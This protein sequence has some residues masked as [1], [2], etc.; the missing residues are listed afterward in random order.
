[1]TPVDY[2]YLDYYQGDATNEPESI[3]GKTTLKTVY[4]FN[5]TPPVLSPEQQKHILGVQGCVWT[6]YTKTPEL[7]ELKTYPRAIAL[8][9]VAWS[10]QE[11]RNWD[12]FIDRMDNQFPRLQAMGVKY[13][14]GSFVTEISTIRDAANN[15]NLV[16]ISS[17]TKGMD[18]RF[19]TDGSEPAAGSEFFEKPFQITATTIVKSALFR[20]GKAAGSTTQREILVNKASGKPVTILKPYSFKYPGSGEHAMTDGLCGTSTYKS[21][22]QGYEGSD[23]E[24]TVDLLKPEKIHSISLGFVSN[25]SDW[26]LFPNEVSFSVSADGRKWEPLKTYTFSQVKGGGR[27]LQSAKAT[28]AETEVRFVKVSAVSPKVLP[29]WHEYKGQPCWIFADE[30]VVE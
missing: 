8:A 26:V 15:H 7:V 14:K 9:E 25:P 18:I 28:F 5:P 30:L 27:N 1:M 11:R 17:E 20:N 3:G 21:G 10:Q 6:E 13:S 24:F 16:N 4:S 23:M 22:W 2:C 19:T 29:D 12:D